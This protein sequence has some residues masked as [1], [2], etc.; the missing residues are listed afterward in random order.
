[1]MM[2]NTLRHRVPVTLLAGGVA[3]TL[4]SLSVVPAYATQATAQQNGLVEKDGVYYFVWKGRCLHG[5]RKRVSVI[6]KG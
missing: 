6:R 5:H 4:A 2:H 1:M 3:L